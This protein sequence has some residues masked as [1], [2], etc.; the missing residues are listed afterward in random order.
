[1]LY[2]L[3]WVWTSS[4][5]IQPFFFTCTQWMRNLRPAGLI[6]SFSLTCLMKTTS[7][8]LPGLSVH[9]FTCVCFCRALRA[10]AEPRA[11]PAPSVC[12]GAPAPRA[13]RAPP[14][15]RALRWVSTVHWAVQHNPP[16]RVLLVPTL[17]FT[18]SIWVLR[19]PNLLIV[20]SQICT[21]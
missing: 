18:C 4:Q 8:K 13:R 9:A 15:R 7:W 14:E 3:Y 20:E 1:M 5:S 19:I 10:S 21:L 16:A 12:P 17:V 2:G 6:N 11:P